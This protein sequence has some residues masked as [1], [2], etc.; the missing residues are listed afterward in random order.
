MQHAR[1]PY[2]ALDTFMVTS[3]FTRGTAG[4]V[5]TDIPAFIH[6]IDQNQHRL[7]LHLDAEPLQCRGGY[8]TGT[9]WRKIMLE[10][11]RCAHK[12]AH[13]GFGN[14]GMGSF[15]A[16]LFNSILRCS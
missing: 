6:F 3:A 11:L 15:D 14:L 16:N 2:M 13:V 7:G 5:T 1:M 8:P 10:I 4:V 12:H 9:R